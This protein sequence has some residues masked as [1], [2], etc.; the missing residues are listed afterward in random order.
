MTNKWK[1]RLR[2]QWR[3]VRVLF[4]ESKISLL[5]F[6][7][8]VL[9]GGLILSLTYSIEG[10]DARLG[11]FEAVYAVFTLIFF[12]ISIP[13][14]EAWYL[15]IF[16]FL[17]PILG[18]LVIVDGVLRFGTAL[19]NK[20][21][22]GQK[23][24]VAMA[25]TYQNHVVICGFGKVGYRTALELLK[26]GREVVAID[27]N[28]DGRFV[29]R[30]AE[31]G[32]TT[33]IAD[34]RRTRTLL[35]A[36]VDRADVIIPCTDDELTNLDIALDAREL[37]KD[38]KVVMRMFDPD[39]ARRME[40]GFG[41]HTAYSTSAL[42]APIFAAA[43]MR[44]DIRHSFYLGETLLN[45]SE[46]QVLPASKLAGQTVEA[47]EKEEEVSVVCYQHGEL[48]DMHPAPDLPIKEGVKLLLLASLETLQR[49]KRLNGG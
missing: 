10:S 42:S 35:D 11:Y 13:F 20:Q 6:V 31:M 44:L 48:T 26:F 28:P 32:I 4:N 38:I 33:L 25:S 23:W 17:V 2:A 36:R 9:G 24:Q 16:F 21:A 14:P 34:A 18:L 8:L 37:N 41:I 40:Q 30:A 43:A 3:D 7:V 12:E 45:L 46:I 29:E 1:H 19:T 39:L 5:L 15:R 49:L 22:R 27:I 47:L